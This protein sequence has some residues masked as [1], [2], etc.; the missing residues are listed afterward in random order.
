M[1]FRFQRLRCRW[2]PLPTRPAKTTGA[3]EATYP[4]VRATALIVWRTTRWVSAAAIP[5]PCGTDSSSCPVEYSG[6]NC[7]TPGALLLEGADQRGRERL[8]VRE[9]DRAVGGA[10]VGRRRVRLVGARRRAMAEEELDLVPAAELEPVAGEALEHPAGERPGTS[11]V[12]LTLLIE[13][14]HRRERPSGA[15]GERDGSAPGPASAACRPPVRR[16][17]ARR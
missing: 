14:V 12:G 5:T 8:D 16:C 4:W 10:G 7:I 3:N 9:R 2:F 1:P 13:L 6:W 11:R 17:A 15:R